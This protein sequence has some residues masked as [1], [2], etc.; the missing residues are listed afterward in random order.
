MSRTIHYPDA[1]SLAL[2]ADKLRAGTLVAFP[3]ET[4][5]GLGADATNDK[6]VAGIYAAKGRPSFNPLIVHLA[7]ADDAE[8]FAVI[9]PLARQLITAFWP[10]PLTLVLDRTPDCPLALLVSAGLDTVALRVPS[11]P[12]AHALLKASDLPLAAPSANKSGRVSPTTALHVA[13]EF[14]DIDILDGGACA[15]GLES[16]VIDA[17]GTIPILLRPGGITEEDITAATGIVPIHPTGEE[18]VFHS[19]GMLA[20]HYAPDRPVRLNA[21]QAT[22]GEAML[23]FGPAMASTLNLSPEGDLTEAAA[24]LFAYLR[25]LD[26]S[27]YT[28]IAVSPIPETGL[29]IAINDRLRRAAADKTT[30]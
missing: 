5:Y 6:A 19:P 4:V 14:D 29:G 20:S 30:L 16:T 9:T 12:V 28:G 13:E 2:C 11:H 15:V 7:F 3:T 21:Q 1:E 8:K 25:Q 27:P 10:G 18:G 23:G 26:T 24:H 22:T 17:R